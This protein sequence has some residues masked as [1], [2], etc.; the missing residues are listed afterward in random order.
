MTAVSAPSLFA[1]FDYRHFLRDHFAHKKSLNR[2][3]SHRAFA[4]KAGYNSSGLYLLLVHGKQNLTPEL[5]PKFARALELNAR[6]TE[7]FSHLADFTHAKSALAKQQAFDKMITLLPPSARNLGREQRDYYASWHNVA[8]REALSVL[9]VGDDYKALAAFLEPS[10]RVPEVKA[11]VKLLDSLGL[12]R[13]NAR[14]HWKA[15]DASLVS[16][17][18][19]GVVTVRRFQKEMM[20]LGKAALDAFPREERNIS[21][22]TFSLSPEGWERASL[23]IDAFLKEIAELVRSD[24]KEDRVYQ[25][26]VQLFPL[27][28]R[29]PA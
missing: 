17:P 22:S 25:F 2:H 15:T 6:E 9:D 12:I 28:Q 3:Y 5:I 21:C 11:A 8:V 14:G 29:K 23:K 16:S 1:Y 26:N 10:L 24:A 7:Y 20:D 18:E 27:S 19:L 13:K 4:R